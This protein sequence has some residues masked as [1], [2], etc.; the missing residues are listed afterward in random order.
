MGQQYVT[1]RRPRPPPGQATRRAAVF[2]GA[3]RTVVLQP[4]GDQPA[5]TLH[6]L[7]HRL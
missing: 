1:E 5:L 7:Q 4:G 2:A 3:R 6:L